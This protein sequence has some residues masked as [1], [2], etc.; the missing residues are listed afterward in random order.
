MGI[1]KEELP[2]IFDRFYRAD[3][4]RSKN[5][6]QGYGLGLSIAKRIVD[7][8]KGSISA[9]STVGKGTTFIIYLPTKVEKKVYK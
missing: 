4:S 8:H 9:E 6:I 7:F 3:K 5:T 2:F 1:G